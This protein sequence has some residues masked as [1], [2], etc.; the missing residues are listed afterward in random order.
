MLYEKIDKSDKDIVFVYTTCPSVQ[1][2]RDIG[3]SAVNQKLAISAD[4]WIINSIYPWSNVIQ[5]GEQ[6]MLMFA[7]QK[8]L[9]D[10][11]MKHI[12]K[13]HSYSVPVVVRT[14]ISMANQPYTF[15]VDNTLTSDKEYITETEDEIKKK[16]ERGYHYDRLK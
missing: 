14:D 8:G 1:E 2:A 15:W 13:E 9:S 7:T 6:Y 5:E 4:Y 3:L 11:L 16:N 10:T 12:E